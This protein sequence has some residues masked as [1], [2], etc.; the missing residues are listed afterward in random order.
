MVDTPQSPA[1]RARAPRVLFE[2][3]VL[4]TCPTPGGPQLTLTRG[5][6]AQRL[7]ER[8]MDGDGMVELEL[9]EALLGAVTED[10]LGLGLAAAGHLPTFVAPKLRDDG[11][12]SGDIVYFAEV[13]DIDLGD[14]ALSRGALISGTAAGKTAT[15]PRDSVVLA[16][17]LEAPA[18]DVQ[19]FRCLRYRDGLLHHALV[20]APIGPAG[21]FVLA[22]LGLDFSYGLAALLSSIE[23]WVVRLASLL[24]CDR[25]VRTPAEGVS[26]QSELTPVMVE[27]TSLDRWSLGDGALGHL[28]WGAGSRR[29]T[30]LHRTHSAQSMDDGTAPFTSANHPSRA[31]NIP[32]MQRR[33]TAASLQ[34]WAAARACCGAA[35][36]RALRRWRRPISGRG[37]W[38]RPGRSASA[39]SAH[40]LASA[41]P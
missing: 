36:A 14:F 29:A 17:E 38:N 32:R 33:N 11:G 19:R 1:A 41:R 21:P 13:G 15:W 2:C 31:K 25:T 26:L 8:T 40:C 4:G 9:S 39:T 27:V 6:P 5:I 10:A 7:C 24:T 35:R 20:A 37:G 18:S 16:V 28:E 34:L 12:D 30:G 22:A 23:G 3:E